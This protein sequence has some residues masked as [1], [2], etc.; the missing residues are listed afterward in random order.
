M[1]LSLN[2]PIEAAPSA[3]PLLL[4]YHDHDE[5]MPEA[6]L[7]G[8]IGGFAAGCML[9]GVMLTIGRS[10]LL[11]VA[12]GAPISDLEL[13]TRIA[14]L[15]GMGFVG[16][17]L[18]LV[19]LKAREEW[20]CGLLHA[21]HPVWALVSGAGYA[22]AIFGP[23]LGA[24]ASFKLDRFCSVGVWTLLLAYPLAAAFWMV[25]RQKKVLKAEG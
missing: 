17:S 5:G 23:A 10:M 1:T 4:A 11:H 20:S 21:R 14:F 7:F 24:G 8:P 25:V 16:S 2:T 12:E 6:I 3:A 15:F 22:A 19:V 13:L 18:L 9:M